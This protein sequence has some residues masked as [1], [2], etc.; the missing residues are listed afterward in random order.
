MEVICS[1]WKLRGLRPLELAD[2]SFFDVDVNVNVN[3]CQFFRFAQGTPSRAR[4]VNCRQLL[5][6]PCKR[7][8]RNLRKSTESVIPV[9]SVSKERTKGH[10][11]VCGELQTPPPTPFPSKARLPVAFPLDGRGDCAASINCL[12]S[13]SLCQKNVSLS[14]CQK[15]SLCQNC[16]L[17]IYFM[18][19][20]RA[21]WVRL[22]KTFM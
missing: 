14:L 6:T 4:L 15:T 2:I 5:L 17:S 8:Q 12:F 11:A 20:L 9:P 1:Y 18:E 22:S 13:L 10:R 19:Y 3:Y 21:A 16:Q 7:A